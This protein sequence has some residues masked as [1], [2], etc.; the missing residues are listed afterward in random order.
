MST[1]VSTRPDPPAS[2]K[3]STTGKS[4]RFRRW[5]TII[6]TL[7]FIF[8]LF[9]VIRTQG[10]V[11]GDEFSPTHFQQRSFSFYELPLLHVQITPIKRTASTPKTATHV[12]LTGLIKPYTGAPNTWH[13]VAI[14]RGLTG[15]TPANA[16]LLV[17]QLNLKN[18]GANYWEEWSTDHK[19]RAKIF[20][21]VIQKLAERELYILMPGLFEIAQDDQTPQ[22]LQ[23]KIDSYLQTE[24][25]SLITDM[26]DSKRGPLAQQLLKEA[27]ADFPD[28]PNFQNLQL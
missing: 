13:L 17:D 14:S 11:W 23:N 10:H 20:W 27:K 4:R 25:L 6:S 5:T 18:G 21:P 7:I 16:N 15:T 19:P 24:Y 8:I 28:D 22:E 26:R 9:I 1:S 12:R 3:R 2:P